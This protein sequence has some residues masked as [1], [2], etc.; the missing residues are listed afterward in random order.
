M[1]GHLP[2]LF[3]QIPAYRDPEIG[4]TLTDMFRNA[5]YPER[6]RVVLF[7]QR[8][9][10]ETLPTDIRD[11]RNL[12]I[13]ECDYTESKGVN[14]A[15]N[16][17]QKRWDGEEY[18]LFL[19]SHHRFAPG[20]DSTLVGLHEQLVAD[21]VERPILS[22]YLPPYRPRLDPTGR[23]TRPLKLYPRA[24]ENGLLG[25]PVGY[26][27]PFVHRLQ[28]PIKGQFASLHFLFAS[29]NFNLDVPM[30]PESY[31]SGDEVAVSLR[32][33]TAGYDVFHPHI[34]LGW[35]CYDHSTRKMHW[36][37]H[38]ASGEQRTRSISLLHRLVLGNLE[39]EFGLGNRR[40]VSE[41][42]SLLPCKLAAGA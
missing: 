30:D 19:D 22:S 35:H 39:G 17:T 15:R 5:K 1:A 13:L 33:F 42:E 20:W 18:T 32:A 7:W 23:G 11:R 14:W 21:G 4:P 12:E 6:L 16:F 29:G 28:N 27:I 34:I 37:D 40:N 36:H 38:A 8:A 24:G 9:K 26:P 3:V 10:D 2:N 31:F 41:F 25:N